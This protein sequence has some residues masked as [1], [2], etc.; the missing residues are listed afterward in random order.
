MK[1]VKLK[2]IVEAG[3]ANGAIKESEVSIE[4]PMTLQEEIEKL[5][6]TE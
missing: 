5:N 4:I 2:N 6:I 1:S 3:L